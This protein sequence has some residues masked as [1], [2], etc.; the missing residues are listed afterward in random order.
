MTVVNALADL[1][2]LK[3]VFDSLALLLDVVLEH[4]DRVV[5]AALVAYFSSPPTAK[6]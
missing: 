1:E 5:R 4:S 3:V 2:K 6:G